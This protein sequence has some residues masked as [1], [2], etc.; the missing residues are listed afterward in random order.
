MSEIAPQI[1]KFVKELS[2]GTVALVLLSVLARA[3]EPLYGYQ[4]AK[5]LDA[6][7]AGAV[8]G[9]QSAIYPVLRNLSAA[10]LL[11]SHVEPSI[12]GPPRRYYQIT[13]LG[14]DVLAEWRLLWDATRDFV[15]A[16]LTSAVHPP[17]GPQ[18]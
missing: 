17:Q 7:G 14:R 1:K 4:I 18:S 5:R 6:R 9:K 3:S 13:A 8:A 10:G 15:D 16:E 12:T 2:A 11:D